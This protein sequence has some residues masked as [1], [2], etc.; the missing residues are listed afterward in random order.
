MAASWWRDDGAS[1]AAVAARVIRSV[2]LNAMH[3]LAGQGQV[4]GMTTC[5]DGFSGAVEVSPMAAQVAAPV[6]ANRL[7]EQAATFTGEW[8][9]QWP[10]GC[11]LA[12]SSIR[13]STPGG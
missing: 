6:A 9:W 10:A 11:H 4:S 1:P 12:A 8:W 2:E 3:A 7:A 5:V 13:R